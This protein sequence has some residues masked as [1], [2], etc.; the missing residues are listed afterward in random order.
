MDWIDGFDAHYFDNDE[1]FYN[2]I[3][4]IAGLDP[5]TVIDDWQSNLLGD[6]QSPFAEFVREAGLV[7]ALKQ[8][9]AKMRMNLHRGRDYGAG[10]SINARSSD[11]C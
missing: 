10:D 7:S 11:D 9:W 1:P 4:A 2:Q 5:L 3:D 8:T 6:F